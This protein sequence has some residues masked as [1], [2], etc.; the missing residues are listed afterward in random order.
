MLKVEKLRPN[1]SDIEGN[2]QC[3]RMIRIAANFFDSLVVSLWHL[4]MKTRI[5]NPSK[6]I[7]IFE[8]K[9][10]PINKI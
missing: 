10:K 6:K 4:H 8:N 3:L 2:C 7:I 9:H 5:I 1:N